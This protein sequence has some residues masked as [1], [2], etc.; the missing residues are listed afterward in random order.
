[1]YNT[2]LLVEKVIRDIASNKK[3]GEDLV[4]A[5]TKLPDTVEEC[6]NKQLA[7][8]LRR[9]LPQEC[10]ESFNT[11]ANTI[12]SFLFNHSHLEWVWTHRKDLFKSINQIRFTC[13]LF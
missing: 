5:I 1:M 6:G 12:E 2:S 10:L 8:E 4:N 11:L 13:P 7:D 3:F 9:D